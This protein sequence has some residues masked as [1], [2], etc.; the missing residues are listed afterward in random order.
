[1]P[2]RHIR[3]KYVVPEP[4]QATKGLG[5]LGLRPRKAAGQGTLGEESK[6]LYCYLS[7]NEKALYCYL[8]SNENKGNE[9][10]VQDFFLKHNFFTPPLWQRRILKELWYQV[11]RWSFTSWGFPFPSMKVSTHVEKSDYNCVHICR[12]RKRLETIPCLTGSF[13]QGHLICLAGRKITHERVYFDLGDR[14]IKSGTHPTEDFW[15][16]NITYFQRRMY[17]WA[18]NIKFW[19][20]I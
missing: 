1:M 19:S 3:I 15:L 14:W 8:S 12:Q 16:Q 20:M 4:S 17:N 6:A 13:C 10:T 11:F 7:N 5:K 9:D 18:S 2:R